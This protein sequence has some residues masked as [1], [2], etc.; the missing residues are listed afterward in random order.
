MLFV[1]LSPGFKILL[2]TIMKIMRFDRM[3]VFDTR[4]EADAHLAK[5]VAE[6]TSSSGDA[7]AS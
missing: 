3:K 4:A 6:E 7:P 1:G 5:L 2:Q